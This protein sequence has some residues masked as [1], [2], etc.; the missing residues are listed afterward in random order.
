MGNT[1]NEIFNTSVRWRTTFWY[2]VLMVG[3]VDLHEKLNGS[4][5]RTDVY[6]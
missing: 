6:I 5:G 4:E 3:I 1:L 2:L